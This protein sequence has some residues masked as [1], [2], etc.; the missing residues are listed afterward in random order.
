MKV[1]VW[2]KPS[3]LDS[4][5]PTKHLQLFNASACEITTTTTGT[6]R[7]APPKSRDPYPYPIPLFIHLLSALLWL[8]SL[9]INIKLR[10]CAL[11]AYRNID[12][13]A[14]YI[15]EEKFSIK[16]LQQDIYHMASQRAEGVQ[17]GL[18]LR[19]EKASDNYNTD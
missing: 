9:A 15:F 2:S 6:P 18:I 19:N 12:T 13:M 4:T 8:L 7:R 3:L 1:W 17:R 16:D 14:A 10:A 5:G 11:Y